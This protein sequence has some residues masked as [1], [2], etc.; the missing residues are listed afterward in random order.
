[1]ETT[2][3]EKTA[4][5]T[6]ATASTEGANESTEAVVEQTPP[7]ELVPANGASSEKSGKVVFAH[8]ALMEANSLKPEKL[9]TELKMKINAWAMGVRK[10]DKNQTPKL[11]EMNKKGSIAIA[12]AI[13][14]WIEKDLPDK[15]EAEMK[16]ELE[17]KEI[18]AKQEKE[19]QA[20]ENENREKMMRIKTQR[21]ESERKQREELERKER[22][23]KVKRDAQ[24]K[25]VLAQKSKEQKVQNIL[26]EKGK[27]RYKD[28]VE[29][30]GHDV[31]ESVQVGSINLLN[32]YLT[33]SYK[34]VK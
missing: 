22:E 30:L 34:Q 18:K 5:A 17:A 8:I 31:G 25:I 9:P 21:E 20:R 6:G 2:V 1:M 7:A 32:V 26:N 28:L 24:E 23:L 33:N 19:T 27:I 4:V 10:Y 12:D 11:M 3:A 29:I 13:Q 16:A 14:N 15:S